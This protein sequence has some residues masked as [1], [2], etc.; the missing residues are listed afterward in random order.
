MS[1]RIYNDQVVQE[2]L[3]EVLIHFYNED[4]SINITELKQYIDKHENDIVGL[5]PKE[6]TKHGKIPSLLDGIFIKLNIQDKL[7]FID[8]EIEITINGVIPIIYNEETQ[9]TRYYD[10]YT[11]MVI[12]KLFVNGQGHKA[13]VI[14]T[15][16]EDSFELIKEYVGQLVTYNGD[17]YINIK[18]PYATEEVDEAQDLDLT[19][20][21]LNDKITLETPEDPKAVIVDFECIKHFFGSV[22]NHDPIIDADKL[23]RSD[24]IRNAVVTDTKNIGNILPNSIPSDLLLVKEVYPENPTLPPD[25]Q[26]IPDSATLAIKYND[27][28]IW[29]KDYTLNAIVNESD[30]VLTPIQGFT[31]EGLYDKPESDPTRVK[32]TFPITMNE[33]KVLYATFTNTR[34]RSFTSDP[35]VFKV[36]SINHNTESFSSLDEFMQKREEL[37][38]KYNNDLSTVV[39]EFSDNVESLSHMFDSTSLEGFPRWIYCKNLKDVSYMFANLKSPVTKFNNELCESI[40][41]N[42]NIEDFSYMFANIIL[43]EP[44]KINVVPSS[45]KLEATFKTTSIIN[46]LDLPSESTGMKTHKV[47]I[48]LNNN[49]IYNFMVESGCLVDPCDYLED[50]DE[51]LY[52]D[53]DLKY[54]INRPF[55]VNMDIELYI[56]S[57]DINDP[58]VVS[59]HSL[60]EISKIKDISI[61]ENGDL[62]KYTILFFNTDTYN[63]STVFKIVPIL[64]RTITSL[65]HAVKI[66]NSSMSDVFNIRFFTNKNVAVPETFL[67]MCSNARI[68]APFI[69]KEPSDRDY[70]I[71]TK[72]HTKYLYNVE[73]LYGF[74]FLE[75]LDY[76]EPK[77]YLES[78][79]IKYSGDIL[80]PLDNLTKITS[81]VI[82]DNSDY[83]RDDLFKCNHKLKYIGGVFDR[84][85]NLKA[86]PELTIPQSVESMENTFRCCINAE[87]IYHYWDKY[88][89]IKVNNVFKGI[90]NSNDSNYIPV[91]WGGYQNQLVTLRFKSNGGNLIYDGSLKTEVTID[92]YVRDLKNY[93]IPMFKSG[94]ANFELLGF[95][96]NN[97]YSNYTIMYKP[98]E[99]YDLTDTDNTLYAFYGHKVRVEYF[100]KEDNVP[101]KVKSFYYIENRTKDNTYEI[102][103]FDYEDTECKI[104]GIDE[105]FHDGDYINI[106]KYPQLK[107]KRTI[108][109]NEI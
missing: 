16:T 102:N 90:L 7:D 81:I 44:T 2:V 87:S 105:I 77:T 99:I 38:A 30:I 82:N 54:R 79:P 84:D 4:P 36:K 11:R 76:F 21:S 63:Y 9:E 74:V 68:M 43:A 73:T 27:S 17:Y 25:Q 93:K 67:S 6:Y 58:Y 34:I 19:V 45:A 70:T 50:L 104:D 5:Q 14:I 86:I 95:Q 35:T 61:K 47:V 40:L 20:Y 42:T 39:L 23:V 66:V 109:I 12:P 55:R 107:D 15:S 10:I 33:T 65:P 57:I 37:L 59:I 24:I 98:N 28:I 91:K 1:S 48:Y 60:D 103:G 83:V 52:I 100:R 31:L 22:P 29:T 46:K 72:E 94:W 96:I 8:E 51:G 106:Y 71:L 41:S 49:A 26:P 69:S 13:P 101:Y 53:K 78:K 56:K 85:V 108:I 18:L 64:D 97:E 3:K 80:Y 62:S 75:G 92:K 89:N 32:V 88:P